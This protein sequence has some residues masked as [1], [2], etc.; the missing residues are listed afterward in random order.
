MS[1][2]ASGRRPRPPR[3]TWPP[4]RP[5]CRASSGVHSWAVPFSWAARPPLLAISRCRSGLIDAKPRRSLRSLVTCASLALLVPRP[6]RLSSLWTPNHQAPAQKGFKGRATRA[7]FCTAGSRQNWRILAIPADVLRDPAQPLELFA[8]QECKSSTQMRPGKSL[9]ANSRDAYRT[10]EFAGPAWLE[11]VAPIAVPDVELVADHWKQ[12]R[13]GAEQELAVFGR[14]EIQLG[15]DFRGAAPVP[16][17]AVPIFGL[18]ANRRGHERAVYTPRGRRRASPDAP[19]AL[20]L[21]P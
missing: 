15:E 3:L 13:M 14:L 8:T 20:Q 9:R 6:V 2:V 11:A 7:R 16:A 12:H 10:S 21:S 17:Q 19:H 4:L 5:A 18:E 1:S